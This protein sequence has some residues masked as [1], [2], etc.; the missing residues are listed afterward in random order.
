VIFLMILISLAI[1]ILTFITIML[2]SGNNL[3]VCTGPAIGSR[4]LSKNFGILLG[5]VGFTIGLITQGSVMEKSV[6]ILLPNLT[7]VIQSEALLVTI[8]IFVI[9]DFIRVPLSYTMSLTG[10]LAGLSI[11]GGT[12]TNQGF[13]IQTIVMW[14]VAPLVTVIFVFFVLKIFHSNFTQDVWR[15]LKIYK[16]MIIILSFSTSYVLGANTLGLIVATGGINIITLIS[17][18]IA[19]FLGSF[20][21]SSGEIKRVSQELFLMRYPNTTVTLFSSTVLVEIATI[22]R[23]PLSNTQTLSAAVFGAGISYKTKLMSSKPFLKIVAGWIIASL[24]SLVI[25][26]IIG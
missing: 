13:L 14:A 1:A 24:L 9:A 25:G 8:L 22:F 12:S 15:R 6:N 23:I 19:I 5:A 7:A 11:A 3:S 2:V 17:A 4:I 16:I 10:L 20:Y 21:L 26:I 18:V